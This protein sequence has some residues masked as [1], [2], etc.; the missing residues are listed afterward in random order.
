MLYTKQK[1]M[2]YVN[3]FLGKDRK[4][5]IQ[6]ADDEGNFSDNHD[7]VLLQ[8]VVFSQ[9]STIACFTVRHFFIIMKSV[10]SSR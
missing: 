2:R 5:C 3:I 1:L 6:V 4:R 10:D 7:D 8:R 9:S